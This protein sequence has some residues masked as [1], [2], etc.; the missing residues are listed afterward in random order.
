MKI[1]AIESS[2][3]E[4][5]MAILEGNSR[6]LKLKKNIVYSQANIHKQ[7]GGVVPEVAARQHVETIIPVMDN[8]LGKSRLATID[9]VAV[10]SGPGLI[11]SLVLGV[12]AAKTLA[13]ASSLPLI[14]VNHI[15]GHIYSNWLSNKKLVAD[16]AKLF[17]A[18]VLIVSGGHTELVLMKN[19]GD[20]KLLGQTLD[21]AAG[22]AY[23]KVA[24]L[25]NLGYP[26]GPIV[27]QMA[28]DG[29]P[30]AYTFP[31]PMIDRPDYNFSFS[32]LKTAVLYALEKKQQVSSQD[33][34]DICASF[35][36]A[37][38]EV[39]VAKTI[40]A[41]KEQGAKAILLAGGVSANDNLKKHL[42]QKAKEINLPFFYPDLKYTGDNAAMIAV[43]AYYN[44]NHQ[45]NKVLVG[46]KVF[47]LVPQ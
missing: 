41:A 21:D 40:K 32:G 1:L 28:K 7:Y 19:H 42:A 23:D 10:T 29:N 43:A 33:V 3:D 2:C 46:N 47:D 31:R 37:L 25:L 44:I 34:K 6:S 38:V 30:K 9:Y 13:W 27:S 16:D 35:Q 22:E 36:V 8:L 39:L 17:P 11:T 14:G 4:T 26:G 45:R 24:K 15:E 20:Y 12:T 5:A 18:L